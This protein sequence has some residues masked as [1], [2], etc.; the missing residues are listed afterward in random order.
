LT[1]IGFIHRTSPLERRLSK[2]RQ[3]LFKR[4]TRRAMPL[5]LR[6]ADIISTEP[7]INGSHEPEICALITYLAKH[8]HHQALIDIGANIG[9]I[10][11]QVG[12]LFDTVHLFEPNPLALGVLRI[13]ARIALPDAHY[14]IH[15]YGLGARSERL[16]LYVPR[17]N[18]G[19]AFVRSADN[20]YDEDT[21][22][23][24]DLHQ[25]FD[26]ANYDLVDIRIEPVATALGAVLDSLRRTGPVRAVIKIDVEGF[27]KLIIAGIANIA[28]PTDDLFII[29]ENNQP[30]LD[31][32]DLLIQA[33]AGQTL[34]LLASRIPPYP[35]A[36]RWVNSLASLLRGWE[37]T[38]LQHA[39][40]VLSVGT[41]VLRLMPR[42]V[43]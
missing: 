35:D 32:S 36:P 39:G 10:S 3:S 31:I 13:N 4:I 25:R 26:A 12:E 6:G 20:Q 38:Q 43:A 29:F 18:W 28:A 15:E 14:L 5:F 41:Y 33:P 42:N 2:L 37:Q 34:Y 30:G 27:E 24:K 16:Q 23:R 40:P 11:C 1:D 22:A 17:N 9:L 8:G 21:L 19:G 7:L